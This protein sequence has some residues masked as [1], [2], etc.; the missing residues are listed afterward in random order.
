M[1]RELVLPP[2]SRTTVD[3]NLDVGPGQD[4]SARVTA[5][6]PIISERPVYF[7]Y[8]GVWA[9]GDDVMGSRAAGQVWYFAEGCTR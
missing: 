8:G 1:S 2:S 5:D 3:V 9:G 4:V 7:N 6:A